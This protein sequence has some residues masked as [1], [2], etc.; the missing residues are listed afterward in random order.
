MSVSELNKDIKSI[1]DLIAAVLALQQQHDLETRVE[2]QLRQKPVIL[3]YQGHLLTRCKQDASQ[4]RKRRS[5]DQAINLWESVRLYVNPEDNQYILKELAELR[6][7]NKSLMDDRELVARLVLIPELHPI[8]GDL[9]KE[10]QTNTQEKS[11]LY[12]K[13]RYFLL[14]EKIDF[15]GFLDWWNAD[16]KIKS[17][18]KQY[19]DLE[20]LVARVENGEVVLFLGSGITQSDLEAQ[21]VV[22][23]LARNVGYKGFS[24]S[25]S[26]IAEYYKSKPDFGTPS[27]LRSLSENLSNNQN[28]LRLYKEIASL[29]N[30]LIIVSASYDNLLEKEFLASKKLFVEIS[31]I[32]NKIDK[33]DLGHLIVSYSDKG[34]NP[35]ALIEE[36]VSCLE[37]LEKGYSIIYKIRGNCMAKDDF[38]R[39]ASL[40]LTENDYF[41]YA[42][43]I[44]QVIPSYLIRHMITRGL[45]FIG[46]RPRKWEER[47]L[48]NALIER[49]RSGDQPYY[50]TEENLDLLEEAYWEQH[51][52]KQSNISL[53][54]FKEALINLHK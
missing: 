5:Y 25:L 14:E 9:I 50:L 16:Q 30:P 15:S 40:T 18:V 7:L 6:A 41:I 36:Q 32:V 22:D 28:D 12:Q 3:A 8:L 44:Q 26:S 43:H 35:E 13:I 37:L 10:L 54:D 34:L 38:F 4:L 1:K 19:I 31:S 23:D 2:E 27:L 39:K 53:D 33:Y 49:R 51:H 11:L 20:K 24:G 42:R 46:F 21:A 52:I 48:A 17:A 29:A 47:L 45:L